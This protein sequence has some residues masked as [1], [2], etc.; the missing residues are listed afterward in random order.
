VVFNAFDWLVLTALQ[1]THHTR[2]WQQQHLQNLRR[3]LKKLLQRAPELYV[4]KDE[5]TQ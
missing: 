5:T 3:F 1:R 4:V 2:A